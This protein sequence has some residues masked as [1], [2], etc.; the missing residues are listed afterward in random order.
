LTATG[1]GVSVIVPTLDGARAERI[2]RSLAAQTAA[3]QAIVVDNGCPDGLRPAQLRELHPALEVLRLE[4]NEGYSRAVN[5]AARR[6]DGA[7]LVLV[8]DD[9]ALDDTFLAELVRPLDPSAGISM[10]AGVLRD[11]RRPE[12]IDTAGIEIDATLLAF[13]YLN[14][15][16]VAGLDGGVP[17]PFGPSGAAA[18]LDRE[19]FLAIGGFDENL[20]A[21]VED[22][23]LALRLRLEGGRCRLAT[24]ARGVHEHSST[25]GS[26]S[27]R[28]DYL[29]GFGRGYVLRKWSVV[30]LRRLPSVLVRELAICAGQ[31]VIDRNLAGVRG[32]VHGFRAAPARRSYPGDA[33]EPRA[34]SLASTLARR[35]WRRARL[36][37]GAWAPPR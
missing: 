31:A 22:V 19:A 12:L 8:N 2:A 7:V 26:G 16:P 32:R 36:R 35:W 14:G 6:A 1:A 9:C 29:T 18:A 33:L 23:D 37:K 28:K 13:D 27:A 34:P 15:E 4:R 30:S 5:L 11:M 20:F 25:L 21:Y 17:D 3:H 24:G 10:A